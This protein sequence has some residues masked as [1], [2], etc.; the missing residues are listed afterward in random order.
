MSEPPKSL[1]NSTRAFGDSAVAEGDKAL[2]S[3]PFKSKPRQCSRIPV[4]EK[5]AKAEFRVLGCT[6]PCQ[7][8][9]ISIGGFG[10]LLPRLLSIHPGTLGHFQSPGMNYVVRVT[11]IEPRENGSFVG[12]K[13]IEEIVEKNRFEREKS[14]PILGYCIAGVAGTLIA[15]FSHFYMQ[16]L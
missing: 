5:G 13:Q 8:V 1:E 7:I 11:R 2:G 9:E 4:A 3:I 16:G 6:Y 14:N 10:I 15:A 12:L